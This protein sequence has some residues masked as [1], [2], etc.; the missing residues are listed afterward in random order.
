MGIGCS[1]C[2][3][4][5]ASRGDD[6]YIAGDGSK[7]GNAEPDVVYKEIPKEREEELLPAELRS[8]ATTGSTPPVFSEATSGLKPGSSPAP[9]VIDQGGLAASGPASFPVVSSPPLPVAE[10]P[11]RVASSEVPAKAACTQPPERQVHV[12]DRVSEQSAKTEDA[13]QSPTHTEVALGVITSLPSAL[14]VDT[15]GA[16]TFDQNVVG[17]TRAEVGGD[18]WPTSPDGGEQDCARSP[19]EAQKMT[20]STTSVMVRS[21]TANLI[22]MVRKPSRMWN[23]PTPSSRGAQPSTILDPSTGTPRI[24]AKASGNA[25]KPLDYRWLES[26]LDAVAG[27][28][29]KTLGCTDTATGTAFT[30][31][32]LVLG[33]CPNTF[34]GMQAI[35]YCANVKGEID[36]WWV[37]PD[38]NNTADV[39]KQTLSRQGKGPHKNDPGRSK[40]FYV[41]LAD[42]F[43]KGERNMGRR[44]GV[45]IT[46]HASP[47]C[48]IEETH[49][50]PGRTGGT[51]DGPWKMWLTLVWIEDWTTNPFARSKF[52]KGKIV[53]QRDPSSSQFFARQYYIL[54]GEMQILDHE[55]P[56]FDTVLPQ[57]E[58][59]K[60]LWVM[61]GC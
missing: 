13:E 2:D 34:C 35:M 50:L 4:D 55:E 58:D 8:S 14:S 23:G 59:F 25:N 46:S 57:K 27:N 45:D 22:S 43:A 24:K 26:T 15:E 40:P 52:I 10:V 17:S 12:S 41:V 33:V 49:A 30:P 44:F 21:A 3:R 9:P 51:A 11:A 61:A 31:I 47:R 56:S 6:V 19:S 37:K 20:K 5:Q 16:D 39:E 36:F 48:W 38:K 18:L 28:R 32:L 42:M 54:D 29:A 7:K 53:Y 1:Q 60:E